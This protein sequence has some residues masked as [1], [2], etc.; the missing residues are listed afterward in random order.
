MTRSNKCLA[1]LSNY[2]EFYIYNHFDR[3]VAKTF[4]GQSFTIQLLTT[5]HR[6]WRQTKSSQILQALKIIV[7]FRLTSLAPFVCRSPLLSEEAEDTRPE[8][9]GLTI[10]PGSVREL[11]KGALMEVCRRLQQELLQALSDLYA[12]VFAYDKLKHFPSIFLLSA[13]ILIMWE[14]TEYGS[15]YNKVRNDGPPK[16]VEVELSSFKDPIAADIL[17]GEI[18][19]TAVPTIIGLFH[20]ITQRIPK[21]SDWDTSQHGHLFDSDKA[22]CDMMTE[23]RANVREHRTYFEQ[24]AQTFRRLLSQLT[25]LSD[26]YLEARAAA[27]FNWNDPTSESDKYVSRLVLRPLIDDI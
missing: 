18:E 6:F 4:E 10:T 22:I 2:L 9:E 1:L 12:E 24:Q 25:P 23:M 14:E 21:F 3:L 20:V 19:S 11:V 27:K 8:W 26:D 7:S 13:I 5:A 16:E 17:R 15:Y